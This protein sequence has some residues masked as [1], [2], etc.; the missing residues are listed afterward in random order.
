MTNGY[1]LLTNRRNWSALLS[2]VLYSLLCMINESSIPSLNNSRKSWSSF[3]AG[4]NFSTTFTW[5]TD[6]ER[7]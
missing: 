3:N 7:L 2:F 6:A 1:G 5:A 4:S